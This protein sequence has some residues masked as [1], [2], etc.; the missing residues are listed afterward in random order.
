M[1]LTNRENHVVDEVA[2]FEKVLDF[3]K[4]MVRIGKILFAKVVH[5]IA[6][7]GRFP[8]LWLVFIVFPASG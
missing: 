8:A 5:W 4:L 6:V 3:Q 1:L 7:V 2:L